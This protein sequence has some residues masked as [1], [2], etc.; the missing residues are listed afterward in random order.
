[1]KQSYAGL[2]RQAGYRTAFFGKFGIGH[3]RSSPLDLCLPADQFDCF[4]GF[5]QDDPKGVM[6]DGKKRYATTVME[7]KAIAFMRDNTNGKP[8]L[9][10]M[11]LLEPHGPF[12][13]R[14]P[15]FKLEA[16]TG[17][18]MRP[19]TMTQEAYDRL[20]L[21]IR[22][23][24]N[25]HGF[26]ATEAAYDKYMATVRYYTA[27]ADLDVCRIRQALRDLKLDQ[28]TVVIFASD[29]GTMWGAHGIE[30]KFNM[31]EESIRVPLIIYDPRLPAPTCGHRS[32]MA[33]NIDV[34]PTILALAG[35]PIPNTMQG[36]NLNPIL[37]DP[38]TEGRADWYYEHDVETK[39][40]G[41]PLPRCEGVRGERWK[42]IHYLDTQPV[43]E[44]LFD[45]KSDPNEETNL[46]GDPAY[47]D[48]LVELRS[49]CD[50]LRKAVK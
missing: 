41:K 37:R 30:E 24:R 45:L 49:R 22:E 6:V 27:R 25:D 3:P 34:A 33:L 16:P 21:A 20:P 32:Q 26:K 8:F 7:E 17:P 31:Y 50:E 2:L 44:E 13:Y 40:K 42:Y 11:S 35:V 14:D 5:T 47:A 10:I 48:K 15:D 1:M 46:A 28:N 19:K 38:K 18:P 9:L 29:N 39:S 23:S 36:I 4:Y 12:D 43:Q